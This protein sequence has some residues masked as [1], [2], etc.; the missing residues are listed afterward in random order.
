MQDPKLVPQ[1]TKRKKKKKT[2]QVKASG[3]GLEGF[4]DW[5]NPRVSELDEEE[6]AE[7]T[8]LVSS[9]PGRIRKRAASAQGVTAFD[10]ELH[11]V[12]LLKLTCPDEEAQKSPTIINMDSPGRAFD[13]QLALEGA[14]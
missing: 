12:K 10:A 3:A 4:V 7:M 11:G 1:E 13:T 14:P 9:F 5:M 2:G 6:E 8:S